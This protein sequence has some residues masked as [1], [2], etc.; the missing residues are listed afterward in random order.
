[1]FVDPHG[2]ARC[3]YG[4]AIDLACL[5]A[6]TIQRASHVEPDD[7]GLW[8]ADLSPVGGPTLGP[9]SKRSEALAAEQRWLEKF[10]SGNLIPS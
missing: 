2:V 4:E 3:I 5:G 6:M 9:F 10:L 7:A 1:L 8:H